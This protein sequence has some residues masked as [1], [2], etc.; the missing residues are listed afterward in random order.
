MGLHLG[1]H[2]LVPLRGTPVGA[3]IHT[4]L[5]KI[6]ATLA[7]KAKEFLDRLHHELSARTVQ[8]KDYRGSQEALRV[9]QDALRSRRTLE[10]EYHSYGRDALTRR[11]LDPVHVWTQQGGVYLAAFCHQRQAV[12]TFALERF[13]QLRVTDDTFEPPADFDLERYLAGSFGLFRGRPVTVALRFSKTVARY[14]AERQWYP[15]QQ[16]APHLTGELDLT[17]Q[18]PLCPELTRWILSYGKEA[19]VLAPPS[20]RAT[21][22]SEWLAALRGPGGRVESPPQAAK[23][24]RPYR[25]HGESALP[26][27]EDR[28]TTPRRGPHSARTRR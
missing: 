17:L 16:A 2:L 22:R 21:I 26:A 12:R 11:R 15:S 14:V 20:L 18:V 4:A 6:A 23:A 13:R 1:R 3:S 5:D 8:T 25:V 9:V 10:V 7:P 19:E 27:A 24:G 28:V